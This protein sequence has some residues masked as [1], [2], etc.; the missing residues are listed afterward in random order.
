MP[1]ASGFKVPAKDKFYGERFQRIS[2][3]KTSLHLERIPFLV[4]GGSY[5][6]RYNGLLKTSF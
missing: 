1:V 4:K 3:V 2:F 5:M 6:L